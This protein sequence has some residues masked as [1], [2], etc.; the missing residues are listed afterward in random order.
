MET[1]SEA[2]CPQRAEGITACRWV[3]FDEAIRLVSYANARTVLQR[4]RAM[5]VDTGAPNR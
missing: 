4:A 2:T 5:V 1:A 3:P